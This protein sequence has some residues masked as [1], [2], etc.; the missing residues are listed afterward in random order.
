[1]PVTDMPI[2]YFFVD[3]T[4][5]ADDHCAA[6]YNLVGA[7]FE[8]LTENGEV[9]FA[10]GKTDDVHAGLGLAAHGVNIAQRIGGGNLA[11]QI[12]IVDDGCEKIHRVDDGQVGP[13]SKHAGVV[14]G[15][16]A[17]Q[18]VGMFELR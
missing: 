15:F 6:F 8:D 12:G 1:M 2:F 13:Q 7:A 5:A 11:E 3:D 14:G 10:L 16:G 18:H 17:D 4:V 9:H